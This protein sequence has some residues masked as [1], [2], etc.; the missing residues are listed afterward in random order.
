MKWHLARA[1]AVVALMLWPAA[2]RTAQAP[3]HPIQW[4]ARLKAPGLPVSP[5]GTFEVALTA[6]VKDGW[7]LY[8]M[9]QGPGGPIPTSI[10][11]PEGQLF[12]RAG[13]IIAPAPDKAFDP[14]FNIETEFYEETTTFR[15]PV[16]LAPSA[17]VGTHPLS[18]RVRFQACTGHLCLLPKTETLLLPVKVAGAAT[19]DRRSSNRSAV[20]PVGSFSEMMPRSLGRTAQ[21][22]SQIT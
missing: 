20:G 10:T 4:S 1:V 2:T 12:S 6:S 7:H 3:E 13:R 19:K 21:K 8:S 15:V 17:P 9:T 11:L 14:N 16:Q 18:I 22:E 5:G